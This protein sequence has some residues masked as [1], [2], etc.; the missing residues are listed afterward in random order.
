[1]GGDRC[2]G[3]QGIIVGAEGDQEVD[4]GADAGI[5]GGD[6]GKRPPDANAD[7]ADAVRIHEALLPQV[8][9]GGDV[10]LRLLAG[11]ELTLQVRREGDEHVIAGA[12]RGIGQ[13]L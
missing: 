5:G 10:G 8:L 2:Q 6:E 11:D 9:E 4:V 3:I 7:E 1:M 13:P 12:G